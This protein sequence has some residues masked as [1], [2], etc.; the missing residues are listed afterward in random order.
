MDHGGR[1]L[2]ADDDCWQPPVDKA[3]I[4]LRRTALED[5][6]SDYRMATLFSN[7]RRSVPPFANRDSWR[8]AN[9]SQGGRPWGCWTLLD[10]RRTRTRDNPALVIAT[11]KL[12]YT[13]PKKQYC[14]HWSWIAL[15]RFVLITIAF[16]LLIVIVINV[17][18][19]IVF[20]PNFTMWP[21]RI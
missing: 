16:V 18:F 9:G 12:D 20:L 3:A 5:G 6:S 13:S 15:S 14:V 7:R 1:Q 11:L 4:H 8:T 10:I 21:W 17:G 19:N 2:L